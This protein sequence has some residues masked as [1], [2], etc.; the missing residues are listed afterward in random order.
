MTVEPVIRALASLDEYRA[1]V[2]LQED[3][4]GTGFSE[5]VPTAI[6]KVG[7]EIGGVSA[8]AFDERGG[9]LGFVF[10]LTG[11]GVDGAPVHW[12]DMLAVR[13]TARGRGLGL[14]LKA[15][16][17]EAVLARG[18]RRMLWTFDPLRAANGR[19]NLTRLGAVVGEY[20]PDM[21]GETESEL[22]RG[23]GTDRFLARWDLES[24]RVRARLAGALAGAA[25]EHVRTPS[26]LALPASAGPLPSPGTPRLDLDDAEVGVA[27][28]SDIG[29]VMDRDPGLA[30]AWREATRAVF[31][32]YLEEGYEVRE[33]VPD[34][35]V[36]IYVMARVP[37]GAAEA[38]EPIKEVRE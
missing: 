34:G 27:V 38:R 30:R 11:L 29:A 25:P 9:L 2:G 23:I 22:H 1:C 20:R 8:G 32:R 12:S 7:Q 18:V 16:Q 28:P 19:L 5:R 3:V 15:Y 4:W 35:P 33:L 24:P 17:R 14:R 37:V 10:G 31:V 21:Y 6:L 36:S 26:S 13:K